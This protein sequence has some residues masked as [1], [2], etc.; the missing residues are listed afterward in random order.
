[1][2]PKV[3]SWE[4]FCKTRSLAKADRYGV[5]A[6]ENRA[7]RAAARTAPP[8]SA[9]WADGRSPPTTTSTANVAAF[10]AAAAGGKKLGAIP[11]RSDAL[12]PIDAEVEAARRHLEELE[13]R[14][15]WQEEGVARGISEPDYDEA[16]MAADRRERER[17]KKARSESGAVVGNDDDDES[18]DPPSRSAAGPPPRRGEA[19]SSHVSFFGSS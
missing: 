6:Q 14:R 4:K 1:M 8:G 3:E 13:R 5:Y 9:E 11:K 18:Y 10:A 12:R 15:E 2:S 7:R 16:A 17:E 19:A